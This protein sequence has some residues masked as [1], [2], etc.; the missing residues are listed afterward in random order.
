MNIALDDELNGLILSGSVQLSQQNSELVSIAL[1]GKEFHAFGI[2]CKTKNYWEVFKSKSIV[3]KEGAKTYRFGFDI[4]HMTTGSFVKEIHFHHFGVKYFI[5]ALMKAQNSTF[6]EELE[7]NLVPNFNRVAVSRYEKLLMTNQKMI[8]TISLPVDTYRRGG[9]IHLFCSIHHTLKLELTQAIEY[10]KKL[11]K[12]I[13][14]GKTLKNLNEQV[15]YL[16]SVPKDFC[17]SFQGHSISIVHTL[18]VIENKKL[19]CSFKINLI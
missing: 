6:V 12:S 11:W 15:V 2:F 5:V 19:L 9:L 4:S 18:N 14:I 7:L 16:C 3:N 8:N 1:V 10:R 17:P 13:K